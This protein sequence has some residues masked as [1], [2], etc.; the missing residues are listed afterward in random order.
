MDTRVLGEFGMKGRGHGSSL[1]DRNRIGSFSGDDLH[2]GSDTF[3][4]GRADEDHFQWRIKEL[5]F[6]DG[7]VDLAPVSIAAYANIERAKAGLFRI[8][9]FGCQQN[10]AGAGAEGRLETNELLELREAT[11]SEQFQKCT[12]LASGNDE[13]VDGIELLWLF[14]QHYLSPQFFEAPAVGVEIALQG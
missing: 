8:L 12:G 2:A 1:P 6:A 13:A 3:D 4:F 11:F 9:Y 5:A 7:A 10:R 14:D